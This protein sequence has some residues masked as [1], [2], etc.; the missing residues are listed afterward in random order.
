[1]A[2]LFERPVGDMEGNFP[3]APPRR[4]KGEEPRL[5]AMFDGEE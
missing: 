3:P 1:V 2:E 4:K 5:S